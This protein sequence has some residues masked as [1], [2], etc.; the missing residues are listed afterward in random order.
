MQLWR[1]SFKA[2]PLEEIKQRGVL[3]ERT[4]FAEFRIAKICVY[5]HTKLIKKIR[6]AVVFT[7]FSTEK[8][9]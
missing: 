5:V 9:I 4:V 3:V 1:T 2:R 6:L 7:N 8:S